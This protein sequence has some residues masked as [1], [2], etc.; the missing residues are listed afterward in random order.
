MVFYKVIMGITELSVFLMQ[1]GQ[2]LRRIGSPLRGTVY[3]LEG[4]YSHRRVRNRVL[5]LDLVHSLN[6]E[7]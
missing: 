3:L 2:D 5:S 6:I 4:I 1:I 7:R